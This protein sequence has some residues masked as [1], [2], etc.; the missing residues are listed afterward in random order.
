MGRFLMQQTPPTDVQ[1]VHPLTGDSGREEE[2][3]VGIRV[4]RGGSMQ[5]DASASGT[6]TTAAIYRASALLLPCFLSS[7][8]LAYG[9]GRCCE[10]RISSSGEIYSLVGAA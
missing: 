1:G 7:A 2:D 5:D 3:K 8:S 6:N 4:A 9:R 10:F